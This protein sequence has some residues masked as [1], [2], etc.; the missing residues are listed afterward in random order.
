MTGR[1]GAAY[2]SVERTRKDTILICCY[3]ALDNRPVSRSISQLLSSTNKSRSDFD[4]TR[5]VPCLRGNL[6]GQTRSYYNKH[7]Y[8]CI[9]TSYYNKHSYHCIYHKL[10]Q[11]TQLSLHLPQVTTTNTAITASTTS[12]WSPFVRFQFITTL[13]SN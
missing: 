2:L 9:Y 6:A 5:T 1:H 7:S 3:T 13:K 11:Q 8:H 10:L 12:L 4:S